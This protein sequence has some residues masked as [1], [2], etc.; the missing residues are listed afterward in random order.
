MQDIT[1]LERAFELAQTGGARTI[2]EIER[3]LKAEK[4]ESVPMALSSPSLRKQLRQICMDRR[5]HD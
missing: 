2:A 1:V 5:N 3:R 4:F